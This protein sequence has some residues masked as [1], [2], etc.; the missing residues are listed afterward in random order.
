MGRKFV[1]LTV[2]L[3]FEL[4]QKA[5]EA[6][7]GLDITLSQVVRQA[8]RALVKERDFRATAFIRTSSAAQSLSAID[9]VV[10][11]SV[12]DLP[13]LKKL[14][15]VAHHPDAGQENKD[16]FKELESILDQKVSLPFLKEVINPLDKFTEA[17]LKF[18][19]EKE[20]SRKLTKANKKE[21]QMLREGWKYSVD[22]RLIKGGARNV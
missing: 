15:F 20:R 21:L 7:D 3:E 8:L 17:Q 13:V 14:P 1:N 10:S 12:C 18:L 2:R 19:E 5:E 4:K 6:A 9:C 22:G 16:R 11:E